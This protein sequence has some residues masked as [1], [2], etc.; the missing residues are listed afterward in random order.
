VSDLL[1]DGIFFFNGGRY[2]E[3]HEAW[4]DL[5]RPTR[6]PLRLYYQGLVQAA[7]G[8]HH[9]HHENLNGAR[10]QIAKA[11]SKL[12]QYPERFCQIDNGKLVSDLRRALAD[13]GSGQPLPKMQISNGP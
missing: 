10:A 7:V 5:W 9:L 11:V 3:A 13:A 4:E 2:F 8:L 12:E 6:G 1:Q